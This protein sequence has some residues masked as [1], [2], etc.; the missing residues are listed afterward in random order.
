MTALRA[1]HKN[2]GATL[3]EMIMFIVIMAIV[4]GG[5]MS[6]FTGSLRGAPQSKSMTEALE[7]AK[8]RLE[9]IRAQRKRLGFSGFAASTYDLCALGSTHPACTTTFGY[10]VEQCFYTGTA[11][12]S[13]CTF[14][15]AGQCFAG[16]TDYKCVRV[17]VVGPEGTQLA[18]LDE[19]FGNY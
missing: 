5:L 9:L 8:E 12:G 15:G 19:A 6:A 14:G 11:A 18:E 1:R 2:R 4:V 17:R 10:S 3:V 7:L 16:T 13:T